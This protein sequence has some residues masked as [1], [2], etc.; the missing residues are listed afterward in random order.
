M[1]RE[2]LAEIRERAERVEEGPWRLQ[3][4][5][6]YSRDYEKILSLYQ[7]DYHLCLIDIPEKMEDFIIN[8]RQDVLKLVHE[9]ERI[10]EMEFLV[11]EL[12]RAR[13]EGGP[14][15]WKRGYLAGEKGK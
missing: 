14:S 1:T 5:R 12:Q 13:E 8:A 2:E 3:L 15:W 10:W 4:S 9:L 7:D 6:W 11:K